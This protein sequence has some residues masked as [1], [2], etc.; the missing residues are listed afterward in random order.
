MKI[1]KWLKSQVDL[2]VNHVS[3][4]IVRIFFFA[5]CFCEFLQIYL[6]RDLTFYNNNTVSILNQSISVANVI[7]PIALVA[8]ILLVL[9]LFTRIS[10]VV[11]YFLSHIV[12]SETWFNYHFDYAVLNFAFIFLFMPR[13]KV[14]ALDCLVRRKL[15][16]K[17][18]TGDLNVPAWFV[19]LMFFGVELVYFDSLF[20]KYNAIVWLDGLSFW[21]PAALPHFSTG[22]LPE[23][24]ENKYLMMGLSHLALVLETLF[25]LILFRRLRFLVFAIGFGLHLGIVIFFPIPWFGLGMCAIYL[26]FVDWAKI[27]SFRIPKTQPSNVRSLSRV[28]YTVIGYLMMVLMCASQLILIFGKHFEVGSVPHQIA[29]FNRPYLARA[30]GL[31]RHPVYID[32]HYLRTLPI[33]RFTTEIDG[34]EVEIPSYNEEGYPSYPKLSGR[35][36][37]LVNFHM[38]KERTSLSRLQGWWEVYLL[39]WFKNEGLKPRPVKAQYKDVRTPLVL[40][41]ELNNQIAERPWAHAAD[42]EFIESASGV[43][44]MKGNYSD[45]YVEIVKYLQSKRERANPRHTPEPFPQ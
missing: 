35:T 32:G 25:P 12:I 38:R 17:P 3:L 41:F 33:I 37:V 5:V 34:Q 29:V 28:L 20:Y 13:P 16:N 42:L 23:W 44:K 14:L 22:V 30:M 39:S 45:D 8:Q 15:F 18:E 21:M 19:L 27:L 11:N 9:G 26:L 4:S 1:V 2:S 31:F 43:Y 24:A 6:W 7:L 40:D 36:W 10:L